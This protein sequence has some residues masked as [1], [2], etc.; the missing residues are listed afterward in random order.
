MPTKLVL[1]LSSVCSAIRTKELHAQKASTKK[2]NP[3]QRTKKIRT[4]RTSIK[5]F[6]SENRKSRKKIRYRGKSNYIGGKF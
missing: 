6:S 5:G 3:K 4:S 2:Q 1:F